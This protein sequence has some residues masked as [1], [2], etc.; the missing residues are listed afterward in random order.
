MYHLWSEVSNSFQLLDVAILVF[1][2]NIDTN[3]M[4]DEF[5]EKEKKI[6]GDSRKCRIQ[7]ICT[8][9]VVVDTVDNVIRAYACAHIGTVT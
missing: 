2:L 5:I 1:K 9:P 7:I 4:L 6:S 3:E 8:C